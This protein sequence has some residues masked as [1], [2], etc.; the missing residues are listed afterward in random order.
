MISLF[1][2]AGLSFLIK[3]IITL[4]FSAVGGLGL[5]VGFDLYKRIKASWSKKKRSQKDTDYLKQAEAEFLGG[6]CTAEG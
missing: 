1:L 2:W 4:F 5:A 6:A 3:I